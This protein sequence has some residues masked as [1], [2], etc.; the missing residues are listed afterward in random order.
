L[1]ITIDDIDEDRLSI[2]KQYAFS[3]DGILLITGHKKL[4][5]EEFKNKEEYEKK[6]KTTEEIIEADASGDPYFI[7]DTVRYYLTTKKSFLEKRIDKLNK[8]LINYNKVA[9]ILL[10]RK[11]HFDLNGDK[12]TEIHIEKKLKSVK[13]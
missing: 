11:A 7:T 2:L 4:K 8:D 9:K 6:I 10:E 1:K 5:K 13:L 12:I 3:F